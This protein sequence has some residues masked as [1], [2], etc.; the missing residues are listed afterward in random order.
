MNV[1]FF[2]PRMAYG[3][4]S[5]IKASYG[6]TAPPGIEAGFYMDLGARAIVAVDS[7]KRWFYDYAFIL[8]LVL[9]F[10]IVSPTIYHC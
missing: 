1:V 6:V 10:N 5:F 3:Q 4:F 8:L 7:I 2:K 9:L